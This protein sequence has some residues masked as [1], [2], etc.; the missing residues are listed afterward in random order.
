MNNL[1]FVL[2][3]LIIFLLLLV[4]LMVKKQSDFRRDL[5]SSETSIKQILEDLKA[6]Y[7]GAAGQGKHIARME[8][9]INSLSDRQEQLGEQDPVNQS[10]S[11]AI[12]LIQAGASI[13]ELTRRGLRREEAELL[14]RLHGE[15]SLG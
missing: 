2:V 8:E 7:A 1:T 9:N 5:A 6:L 11:D 4:F 13:E 14:M 10:Y 15:Q 3:G 12:E